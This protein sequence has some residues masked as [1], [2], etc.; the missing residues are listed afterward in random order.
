VLGMHYR[1]HVGRLPVVTAIF[2]WGLQRGTE[3]EFSS[4]RAYTWAR[5][6]RVRI[7]APADAAPG[8]ALPV[9]FTAAGGAPVGLPSVVV[10]EFP[11]GGGG[12]QGGRAL[13]VPGTANGRSSS[14]GRPRPGASG[15]S[16]DS[17]CSWK[18]QRP[19]ARFALDSF[20]EVLDAQGR[21][22]PRATLRCLARTNVAFRDHDSAAPG[23]RLDAWK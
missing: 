9:P 6:A 16:R 8:T 4:R 14:P 12:E 7:K 13:P 19:P 23:I 22:L 11:R 21:P 18:R 1:L 5:A 20:I 15:P 10:D 3:A 17:A 2:P